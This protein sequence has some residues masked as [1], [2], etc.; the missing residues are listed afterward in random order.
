MKLRRL[1]SAIAAGVMFV[2]SSSFQV[3]GA[4]GNWQD[5]YYNKILA[6][7]NS[8][9]LDLGG[10]LFR[11][12]DIDRSGVPELFV[13]QNGTGSYTISAY[14]YTSGS[15]RAISTIYANEIYEVPNNKEILCTSSVMARGS[16]YGYNNA[17]VYQLSGTALQQRLT[18]GTV[19]DA[20]NGSIA[21]YSVNDQ[22]VSQTEYLKYANQY[23]TNELTSFAW[24]GIQGLLGSEGTELWYEVVK[25]ATGTAVATEAWKNAYIS[26]LKTEAASSDPMRKTNYSLIDFDRNGIPELVAANK[27]TSYYSFDTPIVYTYANGKMTEVTQ[28]YE[29]GDFGPNQAWWNIYS[30][31]LYADTQSGY[32]YAINETMSIFFKYYNH[33]LVLEAV[34]N[35]M[36]TNG[37]Y[38][39]IYNG[40]EV[41][42][43]N[44]ES[45]LQ[46]Y[47]KLT[48][49]GSKVQ[50][51]YSITN[52]S[53]VTNYS[54]PETPP[55]TTTQPV[56]TTIATTTKTTTTVIT[57]TKTTTTVTTTIQVATTATATTV[58][59]FSPHDNID[60]CLDI[61]R[62]MKNIIACGR[63]ECNAGDEIDYPVY[64]YNNTGYAGTGIRLNYDERLSPVLN[65]DGKV[66]T[67]KGE[68]GDDIN[69]FFSRNPDLNVVGIGTLGSD[70]E[71]DSGMMFTVKIK[72]PDDAIPGTIYP[73]QLVIERW[74]DKDINEVKY[75][76]YDGWIRIYDGTDYIL[77][78]RDLFLGDYNDDG[79]IT[80]DDAQNVLVAYV[81][82]LS[83]GGIIGMSEAQ[84]KACDVDEDNLI[85]AADAQYILIYYTANTVAGQ[86]LTWQEIL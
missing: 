32:Y 39:Y 66:I 80:V 76:T 18:F 51:E 3:S 23:N 46:K 62:N 45:N 16:N 8:D 52:T 81:E 2:T 55:Q 75:I 20:S 60:K 4:G 44:Y 84:T 35:R 71:M 28:D 48:G 21:G 59:S 82:W 30:P 42:A 50:Y 69:M 85:T 74:L 19:I 7:Y 13:L 25:E 67:Q 49:S 47:K 65:T 15:I 43:S 11:L 5:A 40:Y 53:P 58:T 1:F 38:R 17:T 14:T 31:S 34:F 27:S 61:N 33:K 26:W 12:Y 86:K 9:N 41:S 56:T 10:G 83:Y 22:S 63:Y 24:I 68:A 36:E 54:T 6:S 57:T 79:E 78:E 29:S 72:V 70:G 77:T 73:M 37:R 64:I